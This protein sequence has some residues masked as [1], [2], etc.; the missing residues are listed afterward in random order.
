MK[1]SGVQTH[2]LRAVQFFIPQDCCGKCQQYEDADDTDKAK[3][4]DEYELHLQ[5]KE[6][7]RKEKNDHKYKAKAKNSSWHAVTMDM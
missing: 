3:L 1:G 5:S 6:V 7:A 2:I 4:K